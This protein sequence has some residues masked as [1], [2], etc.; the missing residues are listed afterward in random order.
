MKHFT[1]ALVILSQHNKN[2]S[3]CIIIGENG[4][5]IHIKENKSSIPLCLAL[6]NYGFDLRIK[7]GLIE[8][9]DENC[10]FTPQ[11]FKLFN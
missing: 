6:F 7:N 4:K 3:D 5:S 2:N 10:N 9:N 1:A 8:I 11:E